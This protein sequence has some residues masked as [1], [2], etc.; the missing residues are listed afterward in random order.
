MFVQFPLPFGWQDKFTLPTGWR[1]LPP[2]AY[3]AKTRLAF[4]GRCPDGFQRTNL[5]LEVKEH[6]KPGFLTQNQFEGN[7]EH[8]L[9]LAIE[10]S[11]EDAENACDAWYQ[12]NPNVSKD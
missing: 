4:Q 3:T 1:I 12:R 9:T 11:A 5:Y 2:N 8:F 7:L 6:N 10:K